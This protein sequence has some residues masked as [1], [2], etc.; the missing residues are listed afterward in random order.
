MKTSTV[1]TRRILYA[2]FFALFVS[3]LFLLLFPFGEADTLVT[4][5]GNIQMHMSNTDTDKTPHWGSRCDFDAP[6]HCAAA[7]GIAGDPD[8]SVKRQCE[9]DAPFTHLRCPKDCV[10]APSYREVPSCGER[11]RS[12]G[13]GT[14][15]GTV[16]G[17]TAYCKWKCILKVTIT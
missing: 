1:L 11:Q 12:I 8:G 2:S 10:A 16:A 9:I 7:S 15:I 6:I 14:Q 4:N 3:V 17:C 13:A 5:C